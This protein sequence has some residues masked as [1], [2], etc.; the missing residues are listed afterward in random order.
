MN[1]DLNNDLNMR[2][3]PEN[4]MIEIFY[5]G[6]WNVLMSAGLQEWL[7]Y[8]YGSVVVPL[9]L[10]S[11]ANYK[12]D[13]IQVCAKQSASTIGLVFSTD[14]IDVTNY[15]T[16]NIE[17]YAQTLPDSSS[18]NFQVGFSN[19]IVSND[20]VY[21]GNNYQQ[22]TSKT[23]DAVLSID[24]SETKGSYYLAIQG[25]RANVNIRKIWLA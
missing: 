7:I 11:F 6:S 15:K 20:P 25:Y 2:Y 5:N 16:L 1:N 13:Y 18:S 9:T 12:T 14:K 23:T 21:V 22:D 8:N 19:N 17:V 24:I 3:N 4:D 10:K